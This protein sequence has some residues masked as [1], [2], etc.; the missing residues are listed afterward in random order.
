MDI[1]NKKSATNTGTEQRRSE[2][3]KVEIRARYT[4]PRLTLE[5]HVTDLSRD[6]LFFHSDFLDDRGQTVRVFLDVPRRATP[7]EVRAEVRWTTDASL[8]WGMGLQLRDADDGQRAILA[9]LAGGA[10]R[11]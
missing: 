5:G 10:A 8:G 1:I 2:R 6:G 11:P 3:V 9:G 7:L 4:S